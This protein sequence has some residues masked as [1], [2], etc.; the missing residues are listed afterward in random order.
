MALAMS[1]GRLQ[2]WASPRRPLA[3]RGGRV[4]RPRPARFLP[5]DQQPPALRELD[6]R[7][8]QTV[9]EQVVLVAGAW[10]GAERG[11][12]RAP[13]GTHAYGARTP[14][15]LIEA[16]Q[17]QQTHTLQVHRTEDPEEEGFDVAAA[18]GRAVVHA[19]KAE[20]GLA[21]AVEDGMP[22]PALGVATGTWPSPHSCHY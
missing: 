22:G 12:A 5:N 8:L 16:Q 18:A 14:L 4:S 20:A 1:A 9:E 10:H 21:D 17:R 3:T 19:M 7:K 15:P 11:N 6:R 2:G 13:Q